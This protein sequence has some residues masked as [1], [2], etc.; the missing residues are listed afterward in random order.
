MKGFDIDTT[1]ALSRLDISETSRG[2]L[3][4]D[5]NDIVGFAQMI[6]KQ[7]TSEREIFACGISDMR[8]DIVTPSI[9]REELLASAP[10]GHNGYIRVARTVKE[11]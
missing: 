10:D 9:L 7:E 1:A 11:E 8:E 6:A 2:A 4:S 5:M 3:S